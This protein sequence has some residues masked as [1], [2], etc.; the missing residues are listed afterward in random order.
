MAGVLAKQMVRKRLQNP[1]RL[2]PTEKLQGFDWAGLGEG[3]LVVDVGGGIGSTS[4]TL[5]K[6]YPHLRFCIQDRPKTVEL[7]IAVS[8]PPLAVRIFAYRA[9]LGM[10]RT[11]SR[12]VRIRKSDLPRLSPH[13][14]ATYDPL[15]YTRTDHDFFTPQP[16]QSAAVFLLRVI[17]HDWPD[18]FVT[19]IL[20]QLRHAATPQTK[21]ILADYV[22]PLAC[23]DRTEDIGAVRTLAPPSSGLLPNLGKA[24]ANA[25]WLDMTASH[26]LLLSDDDTEDGTD[27]RHFQQQRKNPA[28]DEGHRTLCRVVRH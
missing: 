17:T 8:E 7:G 23:E 4:M 13:I 6:A 14:P 9:N 10:E 1:S 12:N 28:R 24:N 3:S 26:L 19:Q 11:L 2:Q 15:I 21:L 5:A 27:A 18:E 16:V 20:L 25:F 22:L